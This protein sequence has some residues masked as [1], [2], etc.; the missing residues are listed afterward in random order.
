[1]EVILEILALA[2]K[3]GIITGGKD[4]QGNYAYIVIDSSSLITIIVR[5][6][7]RVTLV[8]SGEET[9]FD[10]NDEE[11]FI[12]M[13]EALAE[14][15]NEDNLDAKSD[16]LIKIIE[17]D[18][19]DG[20][21]DTEED[22]D[23]EE[24][25]EDE[26][27]DEDDDSA[28]AEDDDNSDEEESDDEEEEEEAK[29]KK[30][31]KKGK[32]KD[33]DDEEE[34]VEHEDE[35][36]ELDNN[37]DEDDED[38]EE[39]ASVETAA[40]RAKLKGIL[41]ALAKAK[42]KITVKFHS[43]A[44]KEDYD[45]IML[46]GN[47]DLLLPYMIQMPTKDEPGLMLIYQD[48]THADDIWGAKNDAKGYDDIVKALIKDAKRTGTKIGKFKSG[49]ELAD[50]GMLHD[51]P[52]ECTLEE[53]DLS[54]DELALMKEHV[55]GIINHM[56]ET[57]KEPKAFN[58]GRLMAAL[59]GKKKENE[60]CV[61]GG[62]HIVINLSRKKPVVELHYGTIN[63]GVKV[64]RKSGWESAKLLTV[65]NKMLK[66]FAKVNHNDMTRVLR[67]LDSIADELGKDGDK[68]TLQDYCEELRKLVGVKAGKVTNKTYCFC[69]GAVEYKIAYTYENEGTG[70][71]VEVTADMCG[72][73]RKL[74][75]FKADYMVTIGAALA[76]I[77]SML[78]SMAHPDALM[79]DGK[80]PRRFSDELMKMA[81]KV[82]YDGKSEPKAKQ[83]VDGTVRETANHYKDMKTAVVK[84]APQPFSLKDFKK[85]AR[86]A[87]AAGI[88]GTRYLLRNS[89]TIDCVKDNG[90]YSYWFDRA[91]PGVTRGTTGRCQTDTIEA[92]ID[93]HNSIERAAVE[94]ALTQAQVKEEIRK[95]GLVCNVVDGEYIV[96]FSKK[97][98]PSAER[99]EATSY[100][101]NDPEDAIGTAKMMRDWADKHGGPK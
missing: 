84:I 63:K 81:V 59:G 32:A 49:S 44:S 55:D 57:A 40:S 88:H 48:G 85:S 38:S 21:E 86:E 3:Q 72:L 58:A 79:L 78:G 56:V 28:E 93:H 41:A 1:M 14:A 33:E 43:R 66:Q 42:L 11:E 16:A 10:S 69:M 50:D 46:Y 27:S 96:T 97:E 37:T 94:T 2:E 82:G 65:Y 9:N 74:G 12:G 15:L 8:V 19:F 98:L 29:P 5:P 34:D 73:Q 45:Y 6:G 51:G 62:A 36:D 31:K 47:N 54:E 52:S 99:R 80:K 26:E 70:Y 61:L 7:G 87:L 17:S 92:L 20:E 75:K 23:E 71:Q 77:A 18:M 30:K 22:G 67:L 90:G 101:T 60:T 24:D 100:G 95:L 91:V 39:E 25:S 53:E 68:K 83:S 76:K 64:K 4:R 35:L 13:F 89:V